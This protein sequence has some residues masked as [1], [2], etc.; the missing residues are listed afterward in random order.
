VD[1]GLAYA[2][3]FAAALARE[4]D[5]EVVT[6]DPEFEHV[7]DRVDVRWLTSH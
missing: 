7:S 1:G 2:D 6:D 5:G 3:C 4:T